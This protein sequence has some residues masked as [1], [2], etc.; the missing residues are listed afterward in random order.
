MFRCPRRNHKKIVGSPPQ[1]PTFSRSHNASR[2]GSRSLSMRHVLFFPRC[3]PLAFLLP[4]Q[5]T[6]RPLFSSVPSALS[7]IYI[8]TIDLRRSNQS[9]TSCLYF[10]SE[11]QPLADGFTMFR[12]QVEVKAISRRNRGGQDGLSKKMESQLDLSEGDSFGAR[13]CTFLPNF[14]L[15]CWCHKHV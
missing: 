3:A 4:E 7:D 11:W 10:M 15:H 6:E 1:C 2:A 12:G 9:N 14:G 8:Q 13:H 5:T